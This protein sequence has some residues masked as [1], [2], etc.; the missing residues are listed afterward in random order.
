MVFK[1]IIFQNR[2]VALETPSRPP[3]PFMAN[4]ILNFHFDYLITSLSI[5][6]FTIFVF[7]VGPAV[8]AGGP[9]VFVGGGYI[10]DLC[11]EQ[12]VQPSPPSPVSCSS[13]KTDGVDIDAASL[14]SV[15]FEE[16]FNSRTKN[17][18]SGVGVGG[19]VGPDQFLDHHSDQKPHKFQQKYCQ[20]KTSRV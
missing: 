20:N 9:V 7:V 17:L 16:D 8:F 2:Y 5:C 14:N 12:Q 3:A 10:R 1:K 11:R 18:G 15:Q 19:Y 6:I 13:T 4:T